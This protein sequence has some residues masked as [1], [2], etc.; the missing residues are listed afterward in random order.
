MPALAEH[1]FDVSAMQRAFYK[2][3]RARARVRPRP[4]V[5]LSRR[6]RRDPFAQ[7]EPLITLTCPA[8]KDPEYARE[9]P[10]TSNV[11]LLAEGVCE[12]FERF[13]D[14]RY[15]SRSHE[16]KEFKA[17]FEDMFL[18]RLYHYYPGT[19]GHVRG[20]EIGRRQFG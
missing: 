20:V 9:Y 3:A 17:R 11:L 8:A 12:W 14:D 4:R 1:D 10:G 7:R 2:H 6:R 18:R 19:R 13:R 5:P 15:G 16:Y